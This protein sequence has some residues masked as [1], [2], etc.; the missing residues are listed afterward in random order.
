MHETE[1]GI[2]SVDEHEYLWIVCTACNERVK[3]AKNKGSYWSTF[4]FLPDFLI[5][6][7]GCSADNIHIELEK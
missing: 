4:D 6:H 5:E 2:H 7:G 1:K 3:V